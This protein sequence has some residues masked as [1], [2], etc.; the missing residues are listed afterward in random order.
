MFGSR[1]RDAPNTI[2]WRHPHS[3]IPASPIPTLG[4][5][6]EHLN[7]SVFTSSSICSSWSFVP[8]P[9]L[10][11][12]E[13]LTPYPSPRLPPQWWSPPTPLVYEWFRFKDC[14]ANSKSVFL[15]LD[16]ASETFYTLVSWF[17]PFL[18]LCQPVFCSRNTYFYYCPI[19]ESVQAAPPCGMYFPIPM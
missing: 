19:F 6:K 14:P 9:Q 13:E 2:V 12:P 3:P 7:F 1:V 4:W 5:G 16:L 18:K 17:V 11:L 8:C 10:V 15:G